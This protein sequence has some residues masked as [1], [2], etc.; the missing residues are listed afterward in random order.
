MKNVLRD[1]AGF[2]LPEFLAYSS[3]S[4]A[5]RPYR[6][7]PHFAIGL[8]LENWERKT[9]YVQAAVMFIDRKSDYRYQE[10]VKIFDETRSNDHIEAVMDLLQHKQTIIFFRS[11]EAIPEDL[12]YALDIV[13]KV[14]P[15]D[16]RQVRGVVRWGYKT[17]VTDD[18][19]D[20]LI[21]CDWRRL[22]LA[23]TWGRPMPR[24]LGIIE[25]MVRAGAPSVPSAPTRSGEVLADIRLE[26]MEGYG[27]AKVWG[28][29]LARDLED[30]RAGK[31]TWDDV[32]RG[33]LLSGPP[34]TGKTIFAKALAASCNATLFATS[35]ARWQAKGNLNDFLKA[36]HKS[37][38]DAKNSA[39]SILFLD[40]IDAFGSRERT[41]SS[42]ASYDMKA[43]TGLLESLDG[44]E[45]R[46]GVIVVAA[47]NHP[48]NIDEAILRS[49]RL[50][51]H[52]RIPLPDLRARAAIFRMHLLGAFDEGRCESFAE[53]SQGASGADIQKIVRNAR[54]RAR[55]LRR[56]VTVADVLLHLPIPAQIPAETMRVNAVHEI[57]HA[58]V[59]VVLGMELVSVEISSRILLTTQNQPVGKATFGRR[60]WARRTKAHY[61]DAIAMGLGGMAAEKLLLGC[62]DDGVAGGRGSDL[63]DATRTAILLDR[64]FGMGDGLA[65]L[66]DISEAQMI[67][68]SRMD[69]SVLARADKVLRAQLER[70]TEIL[71]RHRPA[72]ERLVDGLVAG[73]ELSGEE[74]LDALDEDSKLLRING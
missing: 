46:E 6:R 68:I 56:P 20:A 24:V 17:T 28:L 50:D 4:R 23:M 33:V 45:G 74:V 10:H 61:L 66:G 69:R 5:I 7:V 36:M 47:S 19:A 37:F 41:N 48:D 67:D 59:G 2:S 27:D 63:Y 49:G 3:I 14:E 22:K 11:A 71:E 38:R 8:V 39:P 43:I 31:I 65:S 42:N 1:R 55:G 54:R 62:H 13:V 70:A 30:W 35:Y 51:R 34:G 73:L 26:D 25:K 21:K 64:S 72:C 9:S 53:L 32:D 18:Q 16:I 15:P 29:D 40:E 12:R 44:L 52:V 58:V 57:G 60:P